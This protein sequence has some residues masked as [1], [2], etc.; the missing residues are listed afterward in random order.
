MTTFHTNES[1]FTKGYRRVE[2]LHDDK[3]PPVYE[4]LYDKTVDVSPRIRHAF[5]KTVGAATYLSI[6]KKDESNLFEVIS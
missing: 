6:D 3:Y 1:E 4:P 2:T 5:M